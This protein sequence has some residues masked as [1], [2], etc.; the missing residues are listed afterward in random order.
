MEKTLYLNESATL[1]IIKDGPSIVVKEGEKSARRVPA[2]MIQRVV[3]VGNM[4]LESGLITLFT[5]NNIPVTFLDKRGNQIAVTLP[6]RQYLPEHYQTQKVFLESDYTIRRFM[7][8]L[9]AYRQ[10]VQVDVLK[11]LLKSQMPDKYITVGLREEEY[12]QTID[13]ASSRH[14]GE[15]Q[16][17]HNAI[18]AIFLEMVVSRLIAANLDPHLGVMH[19]RRDFGLALDICHVL[20]PEMDIQAIQCLGGKKVSGHQT[21]HEISSEEMKAIAV[22]FENRKEV[23]ITMTEHI[24]DGIFELIRELRISGEYGITL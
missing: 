7:T 2:R 9:R 5:Q 11:R 1:H 24:L 12:Q 4:K 23:L 17:I 20:G 21:Q 13:N 3:I 10:Q 22:R 16:Q 6:C 8:F 18:S 15:F 14:R 19:R